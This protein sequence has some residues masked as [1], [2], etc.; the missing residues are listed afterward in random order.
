M[1]MAP[2]SIREG[3]G[4]DDPVRRAGIGIDGARRVST[5]ERDRI[6]IR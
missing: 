4:L 5:A 1:A 2:V 6:E 3:F